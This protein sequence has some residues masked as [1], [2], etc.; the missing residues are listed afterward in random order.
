MPKTRRRALLL[1]VLTLAFIP[2]PARAQLD[3]APVLSAAQIVAEIRPLHPKTLVLVFDV[4]Q[5]TRHNGIFSLERAASATLIEDGCRVGD[6]VV[7]LKFGTG[8]KTVFDKTLTENADKQ[9]LVDQI[10]PSVEPGRGTNIRL[11][12][13]EA[14]R[15]VAKDRPRQGVIVL[16]TDSFNDRPAPA[17]PNYPNYLAYY[18]LKGLTDY[19]HTPENRDYERLLRTLAASGR[20]K[21]YGI[22]V[23]IAPDGRPIERLPVAGQGDDAAA[24]PADTTPVVERPIGTEQVH[25]SVWPLILGG[26]LFLLLLLL[27]L[28]RLLNRP[29]PLRLRLGDRGTPRD[30][31]LRPGAKVGLGGTPLTAAPGD[32]VF[33]LAGLPAPVAFVLAGRGGAASLVRGAADTP[34]G[35]T[36]LHNGLTLERP[37]PVRPGD[38]VRLVL[39]A[40]DAAPAREHRVRVE[41]PRG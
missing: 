20:V 37:V 12:H 39:P 5:S 27:L 25:S 22:G 26:L 19:P 40:T 41:D 18:T 1:L 32:D 30:Y 28:W 7:L 9:T 29:V 16:L 17:D 6:R 34:D 3:S 21:Q 8:D 13:H 23:G 2:L 24:G 38:E 4:T 14:L 15:L 33:P 35:L 11:P 36:L 31:R 10:P